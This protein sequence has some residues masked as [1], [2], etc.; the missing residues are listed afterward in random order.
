M[1]LLTVFILTTTAQNVNQ[2][3]PGLTLPIKLLEPTPF[4][5]FLIPGIILFTVNGL[6]NLYV[7]ILGIRKS[8]SFPMLTLLCGVLLA[9]WLTVQV[10]MIQA[11]SYYF[12]LTYYIVG[13]GMIITGLILRKQQNAVRR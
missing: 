9:G 13:I 1:K 4:D 6:F 11:F 8:R 5:D 3:L 7:G 12:H 10:I 2:L